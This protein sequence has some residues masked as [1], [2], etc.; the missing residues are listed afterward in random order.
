MFTGIVEEIGTTRDVK[1]RGDGARITV[2]AT[3]VL[4]D[5]SIGASIACNGCCLSVVDLGTGWFA[6]DAVAET[7]ARTNLAALRAGDALNLERPLAA[8]GRYGGHVVQGHVDGV[9]RI[10]D[11]AVQADGSACMTFEL[12]GALARYVVA[13]GSVALDGISL[14]VARIEGARVTIAVIPHTLVATTLGTKQTGD[15]VNVEVDVVAKYVERLVNETVAM[16]RGA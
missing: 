15:D 16:P 3:I 10:V 12:P 4:Q 9:A 13:K 6:A 11:T 5:A 8:G 2:A 7:L 14:T 1:R